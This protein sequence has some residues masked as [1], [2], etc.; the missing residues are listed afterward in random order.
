MTGDTSLKA[1]IPVFNTDTETE[2]E[3][4]AG[5]ELTDRDLETVAA[6]M[7][8]FIETVERRAQGRALKRR[9]AMVGSVRLLTALLPAAPNLLTVV[10]DAINP[11]LAEHGWRLV[12]Q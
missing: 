11:T 9:L 2:I 7:R 1:G 3:A 8:S 6:S 12:R 10:A 4:E 5:D